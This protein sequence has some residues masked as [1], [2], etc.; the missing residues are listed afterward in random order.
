MKSLLLYTSLVEMAG[1][2]VHAPEIIQDERG[3]W[4][5]SSADHPHRGVSVAPLVWE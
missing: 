3:Q 1:C 4:F 2:T 5:I